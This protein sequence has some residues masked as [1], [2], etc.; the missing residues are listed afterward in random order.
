MFKP[1][2][3]WFPDP[4]PHL[5]LGSFARSCNSEAIQ[6]RDRKKGIPREN[7]DEKEQSM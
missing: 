5:T 6:H 1:L 7:R 2:S 3:F 4:E